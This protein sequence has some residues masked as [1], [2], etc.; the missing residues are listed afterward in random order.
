M[1]SK[2]A[3]HAVT[4]ATKP[5]AK[6]AVAQKSVAQKPA[7][8]KAVAQ[9]NARTEG[10]FRVSSVKPAPMAQKSKQVPV[11]QAKTA[12]CRNRS[13]EACGT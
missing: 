7:A 6:K 11:V 13:R 9:K 2:E 12:Q 10:G 4:P 3:V 5:V 1:K 8:Q